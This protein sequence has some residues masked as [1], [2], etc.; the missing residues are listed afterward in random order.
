MSKGYIKLHRQIQDCWIWSDDDRYDK[1]HAW[2]DLLLLADHKDKKILYKGEVVSCQ[3]GTVNRSVKWL[4]N[5]WN[6]NWRTVKSFLKSLERDGMIE[7]E[8][9]T[10]RT[11]ITLVNYEKY[12][13]REDEVQNEMQNEVHN[14]VHNELHTNKNVKNVKK[15]KEYYSSFDEF[16]KNYPRKQ[17][18]GHAYKCYQARLN[19]GYSEEQLLTACMNYAAECVKEKREKKYIKVASTFLSVNEPFVDYLKGETHDTRVGNTAQTDEERDAEI[20]RYLESD[21][22]RNAED[23]DLF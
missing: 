8:Y 13:S 14:E 15:D 11:T 12:Q 6:W 2:L 22:F 9:T 3:R 23:E 7:G 17:D 18:K 5:R 10:N 1:A 19:D 4:A 21:E 20:R 16:W